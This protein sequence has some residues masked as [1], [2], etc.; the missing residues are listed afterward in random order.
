MAQPRRGS[1]LL[2]ICV[3]SLSFSVYPTASAQLGNPNPDINI[4]CPDETVEIEVGPGD[5]RVG[6]VQCTLE[7][8]SIHQ[9]EVNITVDQLNL[10]IAYPGTVSVSAGSEETF[11]ITWSAK[12]GAGVATLTSEVEVIVSSFGVGAPCF[13]C[14]SKSD[15]V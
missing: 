13:T 3:V 2:A 6:T 14:T 1:L 5:S 7:N 11:S 4:D 12:P 9:E 10:D 8:P 15:S